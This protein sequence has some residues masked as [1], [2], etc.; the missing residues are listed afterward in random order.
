MAPQPK[1]TVAPEPIGGAA[2]LALAVIVLSFIAV[3]TIWGRLPNSSDEVW[4]KAA[5][6]EWAASGHFAAPELINVFHL[7]LGVERIFFLF[8]PIYSFL[9][10]LL[11]KVVG[12]SWRTCMFYDAVI[13]GVLAVLTFLLTDRVTERKLRWV[14]VAAGLTM[15]PLTT[16]GP[17]DALG[18]C[19]GMVS[20]LLLG[21]APNPRRLRLSGIALG[22]CAG[23]SPTCALLFGVIG[24]IGF[25][26][27]E[28]DWKLRLSH[29]VIWGLIS[30]GVLALV[31]VPILAPNPW[32]LPQFFANA[33][34][35]IGRETRTLSL[36][37]IVRNLLGVGGD[38]SDRLLELF[39][40]GALLVGIVHG[41]YEFA[42]GRGR[43]W[44][45]Y[46]LGPL[47]GFGLLFTILGHTPVYHRILAPFF[48]AGTA[49]ALVRPGERPRWV[50]AGLALTLVGSWLASSYPFWRDSFVLLALPAEQQPAYQARHLPRVVPAGSRVLAHDA[51]FFL[52]ST[53]RVVD[54]WW[55]HPDMDTIDYAVFDTGEVTWKPDSPTQ[56]DAGDTWCSSF[57]I[58]GAVKDP[59]RSD[60]C[61]RFSV[62]E[63]RTNHHY[64]S[65][66]G[67]PIFRRQKGFGCLVLKQV[68][69]LSSAARADQ[70]NSH[71]ATPPGDS[72]LGSQAERR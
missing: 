53:C 51:W 63:D 57:L 70:A 32:S 50:T 46:W 31:V 65:L 12:F 13:T 69:M 61:R 18:T 15:I 20:L 28:G 37:R 21:R 71:R 41:A 48:L 30:V 8:V 59:E 17:P 7:N 29:V 33:S 24:L 35:N 14:A 5:G 49:T 67:R 4:Y 42:A 68:D 2:L 56:S 23:T 10:G 36:T 60:L 54:A 22:L 55:A 39:A 26:W 27:Q 9:F 45:E 66:L 58:H 72:N 19:L 52:A 1:T 6:S 40:K 38:P 16:T 25:L 3:Q 43:S 62:V 11:V 47:V 34:E 64:Y 44:L